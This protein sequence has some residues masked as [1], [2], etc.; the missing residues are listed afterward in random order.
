MFVLLNSQMS[1]SELSSWLFPPPPG[2]LLGAPQ[3]HLT[4][5]KRLESSRTPLFPRPLTSQ[6]A[7]TL[8]H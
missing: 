2:W 6:E 5:T 3:T 1:S 4:R 8:V 7:V